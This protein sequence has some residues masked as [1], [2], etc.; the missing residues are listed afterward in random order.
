[1]VTK[2]HLFLQKNIT[3]KIDDCIKVSKD[4]NIRTGKTEYSSF[5][6]IYSV[7]VYIILFFQK[8]RTIKM[9]KDCIKVSKI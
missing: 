9:I 1:M 2:Y 5:A 4:M 3:I 6:L 8:N 7:K